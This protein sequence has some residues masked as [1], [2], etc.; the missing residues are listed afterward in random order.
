[1]RSIWTSTILIAL[2][3]LAL[4]LRLTNLNVPA[5][6]YF[7][8][9][10]L[11]FTASQL[12]KGNRAELWQ[13]TRTP[14]DPPRGY[15]WQH[16]PLTRLLTAATIKALGSQPWVWRIVSVISGTLAIPLLYLLGKTY[17]SPTVG[18]LAAFLLA[19]DGLSFAQSR[20]GTR[21]A[22]LVLL[23]LTSLVLVIRGR[24][25]L[26]AIA[27]GLALATKWVALPLLPL[28]ILN[29]RIFAKQ[30]DAPLSS[31]LMLYAIVPAL[32]YT[33]TYLPYFATGANLSDFLNLTKTILTHL[34]FH[35]TGLID[36]H[37]F[38]SPWW[39]WPLGWTP[40]PYYQSSTAQV[41]AIPNLAVF[42]LGLAALAASIPTL[43][44]RWPQ[45]R[46]LQSLLPGEKG[47][48]ASLS[49]YFAFFLPWVLLDVAS[50]GLKTGYLYYYL[51]TLP[52]LHLLSAAWLA[53]PLSS[54]RPPIRLAAVGI[55]AIIPLLFLAIY[56]RLAGL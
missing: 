26:S 29:T 30:D 23:I 31:K 18:L 15:E 12:A 19:F 43:A 52:F 37:P 7:D 48:L 4:L 45:S 38:F 8:E 53:K 51:P 34:R 40:I 2:T 17:F 14:V 49:G 21:D 6:Y 50:G 10:Y 13:P 27:A 28:L 24:L 41:W 9:N 56:P 22:L 35:A 3:S 5:Q 47:V 39:L 55:L 33:L 16:P 54:K 36:A 44:K 25:V 46:R 42:W 20:V 32:V 11:A 1:M